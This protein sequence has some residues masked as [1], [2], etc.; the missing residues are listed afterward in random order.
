MHIPRIP[1]GFERR[2]ELQLV[3]LHTAGEPANEHH[4]RE[5]ISERA[6]TAEIELSTKFLDRWHVETWR[7]RQLNAVECRLRLS[8]R[9]KVI[10]KLSAPPPILAS[11]TDGR[12]TR[13]L[14][15]IFRFSGARICGQ[16]PAG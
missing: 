7:E 8:V 5:V 9:S 6:Q 4:P 15:V 14:V 11:A 10:C 16:L 13:K 2:E 1:G 12:P 3:T